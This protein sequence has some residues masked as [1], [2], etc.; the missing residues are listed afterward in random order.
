MSDYDETPNNDSTPPDHLGVTIMGMVL[1]IGGWW[2]LFVLIVTM[3]PFI[4]GPLWLFFLLLHVAVT[5]TALPFVRYLN[6]RFTPQHQPLPPSGVL[7]R[8]GVWVGLFAVLC[9][10]LQ[11]IKSPSGDRMLSL[12]VAFFIALILVVLE[13]VIRTREQAAE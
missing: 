7:I 1:M 5:G 2:G 4:G 9:V 3:E 11:I 10:W 8:Q 12:P 6:V 13:F